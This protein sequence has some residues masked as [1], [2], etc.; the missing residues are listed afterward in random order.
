MAHPARP[1]PIIGSQSPERILACGEAF[2]VGWSRAQWYG[3]LEAAR[4][5]AMP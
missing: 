5:Q 3:V 4:G 2:K 1:V